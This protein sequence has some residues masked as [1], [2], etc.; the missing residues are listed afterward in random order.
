MA[1]SLIQSEKTSHQAASPL[2]ALCACFFG[3]VVSK[4]AQN[5]MQQAVVVFQYFLGKETVTAMNESLNH[6][7]LPQHTLASQHR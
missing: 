5:E 3:A 4:D 1:L 2:S 6:P 7:T